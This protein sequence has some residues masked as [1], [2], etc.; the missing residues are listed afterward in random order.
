MHTE[1][2]MYIYIYSLVSVFNGSSNFVGDF[3][4]KAS[5]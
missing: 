4:L 1:I 2:C 5:L 3:M